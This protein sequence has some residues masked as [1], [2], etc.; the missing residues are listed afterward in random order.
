MAGLDP[1]IH[2]TVTKILVS[3]QAWITG[4]PPGY[5][6]TVRRERDPGAVMTML[7]RPEFMIYSRILGTGWPG[8]IP[9]IRAVIAIVGTQSLGSPS[10]A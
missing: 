2:A 3:Q 6:A 10:A 1:A 5:G 7:G 4:S 9:A 8:S